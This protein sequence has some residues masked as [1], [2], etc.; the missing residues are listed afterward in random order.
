[1]SI[2]EYSNGEV[3]IVWNS[4][5]CIHSEKCVTGLPSVFNINASPWID[6]TNANS[7]EIVEQVSKCPSGALMIKKE[8]VAD[9]ES[10]QIR[11]NTEVCITKNGPILL[12]GDFKIIDSEGNQIDTKSKAFLCRCGSSANKPFCD[13]THKQN[14]F[15]G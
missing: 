4:G 9:E 5:L 15:I 7:D 14:E 1:M 8:H 3:T 2:R 11:K 13:G 12:T 10:E 6:P